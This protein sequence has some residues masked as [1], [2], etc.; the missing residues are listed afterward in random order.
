[1]ARI[2]RE[3]KVKALLLLVVGRVWKIKA[4]FL[5]VVGRVRKI[6]ALLLLVVVRVWKEALLLYGFA[7][8]LRFLVGLSQCDGQVLRAI[9]VQQGDFVHSLVGH[10]VCSAGQIHRSHLG[11]GLEQLLKPL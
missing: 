2:V 6:K 3:K 1:M 11:S 9:G 8:L 10:L 5:L 7:D 4:L